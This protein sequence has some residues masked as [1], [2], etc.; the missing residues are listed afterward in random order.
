MQ[1]RLISA[2]SIFIGS[3]L[4][5]AIILAF[6]DIPLDWWN[7]PICQ[8]LALDEC[9]YNPFS[10][11]YITVAFLLVTIISTIIS[12]VTLN[13]IKYPH[14][15]TIVEAKAAPNDIINYVFPYVVTFMGISYSETVKLI[16]FFIFLLW[17]FAISYKSGQILMNPL[18]LM[19][20]W[21]LY[22]AKIKVNNAEYEVRILKKGKLT[23]GV[24]NAQKIQDF[25]ITKD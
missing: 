2:F 10:H 17:M 14:N 24:Q 13:K 7:Q 25:Y 19:F 6:Q 1:F 16:G 4:P 8:T 21:Q 23:T 20:G 18:L 9:L 11:L 12:Q 5:L 22:D 3:Y 15:I